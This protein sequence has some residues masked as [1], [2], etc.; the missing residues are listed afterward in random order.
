MQDIQL[1]KKISTTFLFFNGNNTVHLSSSQCSSIISEDTFKQMCLH[2]Y[3]KR[4]EAK[5]EK[6]CV[7]EQG[8]LLGS[9]CLQ[10]S[11]QLEKPTNCSWAEAHSLAEPVPSWTITFTGEP[12]ADKIVYTN[13]NATNTTANHM[14]MSDDE[15]W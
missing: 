10:L 12:R 15:K 4:S 1:L 14:R 13:K 8:N 6:V 3:K 7:K 11:R 2:H 9:G 5:G